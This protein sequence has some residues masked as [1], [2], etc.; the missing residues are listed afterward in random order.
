MKVEAERKIKLL[1]ACFVMVSFVVCDDYDYDDDDN[2]D[3]YFYYYYLYL[4]L[5]V[6]TW[7]LQL[8]TQW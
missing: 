6:T 4:C 3:F 1:N 5:Q 2:S 8:K 7:P